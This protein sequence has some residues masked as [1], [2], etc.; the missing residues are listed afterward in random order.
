MFEPFCMSSENTT[1]LG[2]LGGYV[3]VW[4]YLTTLNY[5]EPPQTILMQ[6]IKRHYAQFRGGST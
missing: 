3:L 1:Q 5:T 6:S 4:G 2:V